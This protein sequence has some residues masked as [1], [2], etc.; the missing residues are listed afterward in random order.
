MNQHPIAGLE[1][2]VSHQADVDHALC[3]KDVGSRKLPRLR[4]KFYDLS[5]DSQAHGY[6]PFDPSLPAWYSMDSRINSSPEVK[7]RSVLPQLEQTTTISSA[8]TTTPQLRQ[9]ADTGITTSS[10]AACS[11]SVPSAACAKAVWKAAWKTGWGV[12]PFPRTRATGGPAPRGS[13]AWTIH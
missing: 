11:A 10:T 5:G 1:P 4:Q 9:V 8:S 13:K 3:A 7:S 2:F 12:P 6:F